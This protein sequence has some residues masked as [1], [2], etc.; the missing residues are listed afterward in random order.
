[1][2]ITCTKE[3]AE[4]LKTKGI[5]RSSVEN[6]EKSDP[7][8]SWYLHYASIGRHEMIFAYNMATKYVVVLLNLT[9]ADV[10][11]PADSL[12][13]G[14]ARAFRN[15]RV[16]KDYI[17]EYLSNCK[18]VQLCEYRDEKIEDTL[19][20]LQFMMMRRGEPITPG[21]RVRCHFTGDPFMTDGVPAEEMVLRELYRMR[22]HTMENYCSMVQV[23]TYRLKITLELFEQKV[24]RIIEIPSDYTFAMLHDVLQLVFGWDNE[25]LHEFYTKNTPK[26]RWTSEIISRNADAMDESRT[27]YED[28]TQLKDILPGA[29]YCV[30]WYDFGDDWKHDIKLQKVFVNDCRHPKLIKS[31][32]ETPPEDVGGPYG[33]ERFLAA[34]ENE[35]DEDHEEMMEWKEGWEDYRRSAEQ[36]NQILERY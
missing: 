2:I 13:A 25:H 6:Y 29:K 18:D 34:I 32:G 11:K 23:E 20:L 22:N 24:Y 35:N 19:R 15:E 1:M 36:I 30:Y 8:Y 28:N 33:Y 7:F 12:K 9:K 5:E 17:E 31:V 16:P 10:K 14:I 4:K 21:D 26:G 3:M 27:Y